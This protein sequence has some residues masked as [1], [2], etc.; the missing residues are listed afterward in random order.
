MY[1]QCE[2]FYFASDDDFVAKDVE[3]RK[4]IT[5]LNKFTQRAP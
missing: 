5:P 1:L 3:G 4:D 2:L